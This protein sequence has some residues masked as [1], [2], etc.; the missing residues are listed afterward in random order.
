MAPPISLA[1]KF[2]F[3]E[4]SPELRP[5]LRRSQSLNV[6]DVSVRSSVRSPG[7]RNRSGSSEA[8][9]ATD[10]GLQDTKSMSAHS[11]KI[12]G[13]IN[14]KAA[15][16]FS[17]FG[18]RFQL[19]LGRK[20]NKL[21]VESCAHGD[22]V[23]V[24]DRDCSPVDVRL[25]ESQELQ[26]KQA[27][28]SGL[29][30]HPASVILDRN[31]VDLEHDCE[32]KASN[33]STQ[34]Y[35]DS[36]AVD[37]GEML[38]GTNR[39]DESL[40]AK[41]ERFSGDNGDC[42]KQ[43]DQCELGNRSVIEGPCSRSMSHLFTISEECINNDSAIA[44]FPTDSHGMD[45]QPPAPSASL[46]SSSPVLLRCR[47]TSNSTLTTNRWSIAGSVVHDSPRLHEAAGMPWI[48]D[49]VSTP[50]V[51]TQDQK[52]LFDQDGRSS[53]ENTLRD[54]TYSCSDITAVPDS[55]S[56]S[57]FV[58][59]PDSADFSEDLGRNTSQSML[60]LSQCVG[61][62]TPPMRSSR[63]LTM[64]THDRMRPVGLRRS[65]SLNISMLGSSEKLVA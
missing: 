39:K 65:A 55:P 17:L 48:M 47:M 63:T 2:S 38:Q 56:S 49:G 43:D 42:E 3:E 4:I 21:P 26:P 10:D 36:G 28:D 18:K 57:V 53:H 60:E 12:V 59:C 52:L 1:R 50:D 33:K 61:E 32:V 64:N 7:G 8:L 58:G 25:G 45:S 5:R 29:S 35:I 23:Y 16:S 54:S 41:R 11:G 31:K 30:H 14:R 46:S 62:V 34:W 40:G 37:G 24:G 15:Q 9:N 6:A 20:P 13:K 44:S 27:L 51:A 22:T 19:T